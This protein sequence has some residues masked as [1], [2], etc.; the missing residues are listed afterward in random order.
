MKQFALG[1]A[2]ASLIGI[3]VLYAQSIGMISI[4]DPPAEETE[5]NVSTET[6]E[7]EPKDRRRKKGKKK[8]RTGRRGRARITSKKSSSA[9]RPKS[10]PTSKSTYDQGS[11]TSGDALGSPG[12]R[13][14]NMGGRGGEQQL[15]SADIERGI[16]SVWRGVERCL[17][18][19]PS[20]APA[21]GKV[22]A[23][24]NIASSGRVTKVNLNGPNVIIQGEAGTCIRKALKSIN[25][26]AFDGPDMVVTYPMFFD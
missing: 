11:G 5:D 26:P 23:G 3:G 20:D 7:E 18:L 8:H 19:V 2:L 21:T 4:F 13:K 9:S 12:A 6:T 16:D 22:V 10:R 1:F 24:M 17:I 14:V 25:Y 15:S